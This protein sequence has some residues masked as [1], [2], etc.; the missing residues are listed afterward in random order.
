M[1]TAQP[2][3][4]RIAREEVQFSSV[5]SKELS[6]VDMIVFFDLLHRKSRTKL[7]IEQGKDQRNPFGNNVAN[8]V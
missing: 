8:N 2:L 7:E 1:D 3:Q 4:C 6:L 5:E